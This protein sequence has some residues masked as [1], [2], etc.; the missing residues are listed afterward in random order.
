MLLAVSRHGA[1]LPMKMRNHDDDDPLLLPLFETVQRPRLGVRLPSAIAPDLLIADAH[2]VADPWLL[3]HQG[4]THVLN[5]AAGETTRVDYA[6]AGIELLAIAALDVPGYDVMR[7]FAQCRAFYDA[8]RAANGRLV[9]H[10]LA[11]INRSGAI[12]TALY[13]ATTGNTL[14]KA[15]AV[16]NAACGSYL[17]NSTFRKG[18]LLWARQA[19]L[20]G[21][22][23]ATVLDDEPPH[24]D[25]D[26]VPSF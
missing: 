15:A 14:L 26:D 13:M 20:A 23:S 17:W 11:G 12:A 21:D 6:P 24:D 25:D 19:G 2:S 18:L 22:A 5:M 16:V 1:G 3:R 10:C 8:A 9:V 4:V 7:H